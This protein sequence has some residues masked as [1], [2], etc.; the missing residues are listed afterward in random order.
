VPDHTQSVS[1]DEYIHIHIHHLQANIQN[2]S[3]Y[4]EMLWV[5]NMM[6]SK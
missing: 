1:R 4:G 5:Q 3:T 6:Y 2:M